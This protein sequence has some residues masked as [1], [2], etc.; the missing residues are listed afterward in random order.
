MGISAPS[1]TDPL[2]SSVISLRY[3]LD[4]FQKTISTVHGL[5]NL[6]DLLGGEVAEFPDVGEVFRDGNRLLDLVRDSQI[7]ITATRIEE[8]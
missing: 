4:R 6:V 7:S 8:R 2:S 5:L 1:L 3:G